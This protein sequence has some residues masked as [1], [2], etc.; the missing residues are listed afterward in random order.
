MGS[1]RQ[2]PTSSCLLRKSPV[3]EIP[4][5][6]GPTRNRPNRPPR[7][8]FPARRARPAFPARRARPAAPIDA[9][10]ATNAARC[11]RSTPG[12]PPLRHAVRKPSRQG[13]Q[14][15]VEERHAHFHTVRHGHVVRIPSTPQPP[16]DKG[17][18]EGIL[19]SPR[20]ESGPSRLADE[21][22][23]QGGGVRLWLV[24]VKHWSLPVVCCRAR[25]ATA[26]ESNPP[27]RKAPTGIYGVCP[28]FPHLS[29]RS[30]R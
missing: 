10:D 30:Q 9:I 13:D 12:A 14:I 29:L 24:E 6:R 7:L 18:R 22:G 21:Q 3:T 8:A 25:A 15:L 4:R 5:F 17:G 26:L 2:R 27:D 19:S 16:F 28:H 23:A 20:A 11:T 1:S